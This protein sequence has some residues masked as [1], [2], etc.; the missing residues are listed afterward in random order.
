MITMNDDFKNSIKAKNRN[1]KG[2]VEILYDYKNIDGSISPITYSANQQAPISDG[3]EMING[4]RVETNFASLENNYF[5]LDGSFTLPNNPEDYTNTVVGFI[6][7]DIVAD[8]YDNKCYVRILNETNDNV[9][10]LTIYTK[11]NIPRNVKLYIRYGVGEDYYEIEK[12]NNNSEVISFDF[13]NENIS[14]IS[15]IDINLSNFEYQDRRVR[16]D[17]IEFGITNIYKDNDLIDFKITEQ[18]AEFNDNVPIDECDV[19]LNNYNNQFDV[20]NP[21]GL[22]KYLNDGVEIIPHIGIVT[23]NS[24]I[25]YVDMGIYYLDSWDNNSDKTTTLRSKKI[26]NKLAKKNSYMRGSMGLWDAESYFN[27]FCSNNGI[28]NYE[29]SLNTS[30]EYIVDYSLPLCTALEQLNKYSMFVNGVLR[31]GRNNNIICENISNEVV[32]NLTFN[33]MKETPFYKAKDKLKNIIVKIISKRII[34]SGSTTVFN[35]QVSVSPNNKFI[36]EFTQGSGADVTFTPEYYY[37][38]Y[39]LNDYFF[40]S[41]NMEGTYNIKITLTG[42]VSYDYENTQYDINDTGKEIVIDNPYYN[43]DLPTDYLKPK[44]ATKH[45]ADYIKNNYKKYDIKINYFGNPLYEPNDILQIETDYGNKNIRILKHT[46]EFDGSL[47]GTIEGV[48]N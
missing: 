40:N 48:G 31:C 25:E 4:V 36:M 29:Y 1:F 28:E 27:I 11:N 2:Y 13:S 19:R 42:S 37:R 14:N 26:F 20:V 41:A 16:I 30:N 45:T 8:L 21:T 44:E 15:Y 6:T 46:L 34:T 23:E 33:E 17:E 10:S 5:K 7:D 9:N 38:D 47:S 35:K 39:L 24:G 18:I 22:V 3:T 12:E 32:D 43:V